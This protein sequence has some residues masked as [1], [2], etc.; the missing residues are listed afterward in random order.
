MLRN[1]HINS[2]A[3]H[4]HLYTE[5]KNNIILSTNLPKRSAL[6]RTLKGSQVILCTL[7]MLSNPKLQG[8]GLTEAVPIMNVILDE[9]SQIEISQYI[10]LFQSFG[11]TL[12]KLCFIGDDKQRRSL[13][14]RAYL[15]LK[16]FQVPPHAQDNLGNLQSIFELDHLKKSVSFLD[17]QC[18]SSF[19]LKKY[20]LLTEVRRSY[21]P[22]NWRLHIST[23]L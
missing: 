1:H 22:P 16:L 2:F 5:I 4:E 14:C 20:H 3:R 19:L 6:E 18:E 13:L 23:C 8:L 21:A 12:R 7:D 9:A 10:P 11:K 15:R 17:T